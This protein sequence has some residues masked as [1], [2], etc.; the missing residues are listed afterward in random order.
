MP[1]TISWGPTTS[2]KACARPSDPCALAFACG[3]QQR[4]S[5]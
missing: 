1:V 2:R 4:F 3:A 5:Q